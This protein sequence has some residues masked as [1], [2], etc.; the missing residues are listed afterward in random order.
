VLL[1]VRE[2]LDE[3]ITVSGVGGDFKYFEARY[4]IVPLT[5]H[6]SWLVYEATIVP[7]LP[8]PSLLALPAMRSL[9]SSQFSALVREMLRRAENT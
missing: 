6:R 5:P 8:V 7:G 1:A 4:D 9:V 3:S 2:K